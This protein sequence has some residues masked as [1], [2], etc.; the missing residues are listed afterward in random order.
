VEQIGYV[1]ADG[2]PADVQLAGQLRLYAA[3][4]QRSLAVQE[5]RHLGPPVGLD[6]V[7]DGVVMAATTGTAISGDGI[8]ALGPF[9][10]HRLLLT[11]VL[12]ACCTLMFHLD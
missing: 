9:V 5:T 6:E 10:F 3:A 4:K 2:T 11:Y 12:L 7:S 1:A 8:D